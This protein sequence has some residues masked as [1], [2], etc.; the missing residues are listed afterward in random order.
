MAFWVT[1][2]G[3]LGFVG[4]E[5]PHVAGAVSR[6][7]T[8]SWAVSF[9]RGGPR[10]ASLSDLGA[11]LAGRGALGRAGWGGGACELDAYV[12]LSSASP[13]LVYSNER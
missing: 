7:H 8:N 11:G 12:Y 13:N 3:A 6:S 4:A 9:G 10:R 1:P 2:G 5:L